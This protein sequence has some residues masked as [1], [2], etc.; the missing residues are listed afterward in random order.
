MPSFHASVQKPGVLSAQR[1]AASESSEKRRSQCAVGAGRVSCANGMGS[2]RC[3]DEREVYTRF[4]RF[5][6]I[7][8]IATSGKFLFFLPITLTPGTR[9][10][11]SAKFELEGVDLKYY[12]VQ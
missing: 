6:S 2:A 12:F 11:H 1:R 3:C 10:N 9:V 5:N 8:V 4:V 7:A